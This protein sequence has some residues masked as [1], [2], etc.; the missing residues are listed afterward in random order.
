[1]RLPMTLTLAPLPCSPLPF[2]PLPCALLRCALLRCALLR[3]ALLACALLLA[4]TTASA[5]ALPSTTYAPGRPAAQ[6]AP[7]TAQTLVAHPGIS[8]GDEAAVFRD[9]L[10]GLEANPDSP[11]VLEAVLSLSGLSAD[12]EPG[13][14]GPDVTE[15]MRAL[16]AR[17]TDAEASFWLRRFI[18]R[19]AVR[20]RY[21]PNPL[22]MEGDLYPELVRSW[23]IVGALGPFDG[24]PLQT[25]P[26]PPSSPETALLPEY[27]GGD[28]AP[29]SWR[30]VT[31]QRNAVFVDPV[32]ETYPVAGLTYALAYLRLP[33][34]AEG[35]SVDAVLEVR[36]GGPVRVLWNGAL[37][38]DETRVDPF[39]VQERS[40]VRVQ[41]G[42]GWNALL[43]RVIGDAESRIAARLLRPDG[44][45]LPYE[46]PADGG[47]LLLSHAAAG[48][49]EALTVP[50][51]S[52]PP[53]DGPYGPALQVLRASFGRRRDIALA[54]PEP[55]GPG[56]ALD[57]WIPQH[58]RALGN[59]SHLP[60]EVVRRRTLEWIKR[61]REG[62]TFGPSGRQREIVLLL[63]EDRP[64][65]A[66]RAAEE[67]ME[68]APDR[69][70]AMLTRTYT[71]DALDT[72]GVLGRLATEELLARFPR[73]VRGRLSLA[74][75]RLSEDDQVGAVALAWELLED[76]GGNEGAFG[77]LVEAFKGTR[78]PRAE[79]LL[80][81]ARVWCEDHPKDVASQGTLET[82]LALNGRTDELL[83]RAR[84]EALARPFRP[85]SWWTLGTRLLQAGDREGALEAFRREAEL[86][87]ADPTTRE[88]LARLGDPDPAEAFFAAFEADREAAL[89]AAKGVTDASVVEAL[90]SGLIYVYPDGSTHMR[91]QT[92]TIPLDRSGTEALL[93]SPAA[94]E[95][96]LVRVLAAD[97]RILEPSL[98]QGEWV[99]PALEV[100]DVV[101]TVW[102][103]RA[104]SLAGSLP[105]P[106]S[107]R[108]ASFERA[109]PTTRWAV[110]MPEGFGEARIEAVNFDGEYEAV[111]FAGGTVHVYEASSPKVLPEPYQPSYE[112]ILPLAMFF[113]DRE[114]GGEARSWLNFLTRAQAIPADLE[115]ELAAFLAE[116][117]T[118]EDA[119]ERAKAI[120][121]AVDARAQDFEGEQ[122]ASMV[123]QTRRGQ[124]LA[125]LAALYERAGIEFEWGILERSI[126][127]ELDPE[128]VELF[129]NARPLERPV[130]RLP[131]LG[132]DGAAEWILPSNT[133]GTPFGALGESQAG[134]PLVLV[135]SSGVVREGTLPSDGVAGTWNAD[136]TLRYALDED[137]NATVT[138]RYVDATPR[139]EVLLRRIKEATAEQRDGFALQQAGGLAPG[140]NLS[141]AAVVLDGSE[142][143]GVVIHFAGDS[144]RFASQRGE[145]WVAP[146]PF[147]DLQLTE[148]FGPAD[149]SWPL[150]LRESIRLRVGIT[151]DV[152]EAW[153]IVSAPSAVSDLRP[154]L[155]VT[156]DVDESQ[157]GVLTFGQ[158]YIQRG[159]IVPA[160]EVPSFLEAMAKVSAELDRAL[161]LERTD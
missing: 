123:W 105:S 74:R 83:E 122:M 38:I 140:V 146:V 50:L 145:A 8:T 24:E 85:E 114:R 155:E 62:G 3:C 76:D 13:L 17:V 77:L 36:C 99:L 86:E 30:A 61:M 95:T 117:G 102:D 142:G 46:E 1:M 119:R 45:L 29:R 55:A 79:T 67:W 89:E 161:R 5:S 60:D 68:I 128:P 72:S 37:A 32:A 23:R 139:A 113:A 14:R 82:L 4:S 138:G 42:A 47:P 110:Y 49:T 97:G 84:A 116:H 2:S 21:S 66:L 157:P 133:P 10:A 28:G 93:K 25:A 15:R 22:R 43:V 51:L 120:Y 88:L 106:S 104:G 107:W 80:E 109:F 112:E 144:P 26:A 18:E 101:E 125:L 103:R 53:V 121:E 149:R 57:A 147:L 160:A 41:V 6:D 75:E 39:A 19:D 96:R 132:A 64:L 92:L 58:F 63:Q 156:L 131:G 27:V 143:P 115:P 129:E 98:T 59:A 54:V 100:G 87:P 134:A 111:P 90:D 118:A 124:P 9:V 126:A 91:N 70:N 65:D 151:I 11:L 136:V 7:L 16:A 159:A 141:E 52:Q 40:L 73:H 127:P 12:G 94:E 150:A 135:D 137:G 148:R 44:S 108:F 71:L 69:A 130:M 81:R 33:E 48:E 34:V 158:R 20:R 31:R 78:D 152:G 153:S 35:T 56:P 154:G